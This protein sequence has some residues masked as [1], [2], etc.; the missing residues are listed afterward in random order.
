MIKFG[1]ISKV[2]LSGGGSCQQ[3]ASERRGNTVKRFKNFYLEAK[4]SIWPWLS[5][6]CHVGSTVGVQIS[7]L[8]QGYLAGKNAHFPRVLTCNCRHAAHPYKAIR[9]WSDGRSWNHFCG[10]L[11][12]FIAKCWQTLQTINVWLRCAGPGVDTYRG[13]SMKRRFHLKEIIW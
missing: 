7:H 13:G 8:F 2:M 9:G 3:A 4:A 11:W 10:G 6:M 5:W 12:D 1:K